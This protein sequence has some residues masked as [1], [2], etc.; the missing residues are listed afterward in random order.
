MTLKNAK[1]TKDIIPE[2]KILRDSLIEKVKKSFELYGFNPLDT[3]ALEDF[4]ILASKYAGGSEILKEVFKLKDRGNRNLG[5]RYDLT[6]P[7]ARFVA[8]NPNLKLPFKRYQIGNVWR[9]GPIKLGRYREFIQCDADIIGSSSM[10]ADAE[11]IA[12][13]E[14]I[15]AKLR[16]DFEIK[17]NNIKLL[18]GIIE[19]VDIKKNLASDVIIS[20]DKLSKIGYNGVKQELL[21]KK[22]PDSKITKLLKLFKT[23]GTNED[24]LIELRNKITSKQALDGINELEELF[25]Y[26][27]LMDIKKI[28]LDLSL[29]RGLTYYTGTIFE[30][31][32]INNAIKSSVAAGGRYDKMIGDFIGKK[33]DIQSV[34]ISFGLDVIS[35]SILTNV[36]PKKTVVKV[37]VIPI[38]T[39]NEPLKLIKQ[40]RLNGI[41]CDIDL[42]EKG[43]SK[44]LEYANKYE[45]PYVVFI[46]A[47]EVK[48]N[49]IKLRNMITGEEILMSEQELIK[50]IKSY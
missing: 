27:N 11:I 47:E 48:Q 21:L 6:V 39:L 44:N 24:V 18:N 30:V 26:L 35:D 32:L 40:L 28:R 19:S 37:Y 33:Q 16:L 12:L 34:G 23:E 15:F 38:K 2:I 10:L 36:K 29:A 43:I 25:N 14:D 42:N 46:G 41:N 3:P 17:I 4:N 49:K 31:F 20:I 45:I 8:S 5:L 13:T 9:D 50:K 1:G 22:I 7:L